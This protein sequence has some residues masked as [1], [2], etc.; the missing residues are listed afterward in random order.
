MGLCSVSETKCAKVTREKRPLVRDS[1]GFSLRLGSS[2]NPYTSR[3]MS[4]RMALIIVRASS[5]VAFLA[6]VP[7]TDR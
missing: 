3:L 6:I 7:N 5:G 1:V 4:C 2:D